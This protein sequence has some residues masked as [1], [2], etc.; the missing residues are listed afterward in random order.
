MKKETKQNIVVGLFLLEF[1]F[2]GIALI[3]SFC[4]GCE[5]IKKWH[6]EENTNM[7]QEKMR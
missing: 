5:A 7:V 2:L 4:V 1:I 3:Y 6:E